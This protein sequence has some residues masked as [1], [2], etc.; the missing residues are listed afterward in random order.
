MKIADTFVQTNLKQKSMKHL[1]I[2]LS[3]LLLCSNLWG[4]KRE[5]KLEKKEL[6]KPY[7]SE[8]STKLSIIQDGNF[9]SFSSENNINEMFIA[10]KTVTNEILL[11]ETFSL[12]AGQT[13]TTTI[14]EVESDVYILEVKINGEIYC[15][16]LEIY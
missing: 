11:S 15:G 4:E 12:V 5:V 7:R 8:T 13:Y 2:I 16:Y 14:G 9:I 10:I 3:A 6:D 1:V